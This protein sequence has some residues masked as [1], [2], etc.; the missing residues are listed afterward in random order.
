MTAVIFW[1]LSTPASRPGFANTGSASLFASLLYRSVTAASASPA[2]LFMN[3]HSAPDCLSSQFCAE[4][5]H[6][7]HPFDPALAFL[8][9]SDEERKKKKMKQTMGINGETCNDFL[10]NGFSLYLFVPLLMEISQQDVCL[11]CDD[12]W[13]ERTQTLNIS[14][15]TM[16]DGAE[17]K[18]KSVVGISSSNRQ[19]CKHTEW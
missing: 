10:L 3:P 14:W 16:G 12:D 6:S 13:G 7:P 5:L 11:L 15:N 19:N 9:H 4:V 2:Q 8:L 17:R 1:P 18:A